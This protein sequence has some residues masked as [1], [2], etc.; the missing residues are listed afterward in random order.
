MRWGEGSSKLGAVQAFCQCVT[1][2]SIA[3]ALMHQGYS[4]V[5]VNTTILPYGVCTNGTA[6]DS[7]SNI[8]GK[9]ATVLEQRLERMTSV[10]ELA[11][12]WRHQVSYVTYL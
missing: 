12:L 2:M 1:F 5:V 6:F 3:R 11:Q 4:S 9:A 7:G 8:F 10:D